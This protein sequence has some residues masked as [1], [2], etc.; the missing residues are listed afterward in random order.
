MIVLGGYLFGAAYHTL[1]PM[2][3]APRQ[4]VAVSVWGLDGVAKI[5]GARTSRPIPITATYRGYATPNLLYAALD[6]DDSVK[7]GSPQTLI[8]D[9]V[10]VSNCQLIAVRADARGIGRDGKNG[11][12]FAMNV[13]L[14]FHQLIA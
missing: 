4:E 12:W 5:M 8:V 14:L 10:W 1:P 2:E 7:G 6:A 3:A 13:Q 11:L 9:G